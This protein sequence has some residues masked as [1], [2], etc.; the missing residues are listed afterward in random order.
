MDNFIY[1]N[2]CK[3]TLA[4]DITNS[5][6]TIQVSN[7]G[8]F[9][10]SIP[11]GQ[12]LVL[13]LH[14]DNL[15]STQEI[16]HCTA[17]SGATLTVARGAQGTAS[18]AWPEGTVV[19]AYLTADMLDQIADDVRGHA[20]SGGSAHAL[21]TTIAAGFMSAASVVK[22]AGIQTGATNYQHPVTHS[23]TIIA[24]DL[25]NRFA[26]DA[27]KAN[28]NAAKNHADSAHAPSN[29]QKNS[30][31]TKGEIEAKLTGTLTSHSHPVQIPSGTVAHFA[32]PSAPAG[33]LKANG[34]AISRA[35]YSSLFAAIGVTFG[36]GDGSTT[37]NLPDLRG[38]FIRG[39]DDGRGV[40][41][42]RVLG[43]AQAD[44]FKSHS[45]NITAYPQAGSGANISAGSSTTVTGTA[46]TTSA[47][48]AETR[49]RNVALLAC[50]KY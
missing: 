25:N 48:G 28:W 2:A 35:T 9:P 19:G 3:T 6:A 40:D 13:T 34:A 10:S 41:A 30:D 43:A 7:P 5:Q 14:P 23:P 31:I 4:N 20:G 22:L 11:A 29:A 12:V 18:A 1:I 44:M 16:V 42:G 45:H 27:E 47:G 32:T 8:R 33:W 15:P 38:E 49:P 39:F 21:A 24:Q 50:I 46:S 36:A 26:T 37:F 17:I